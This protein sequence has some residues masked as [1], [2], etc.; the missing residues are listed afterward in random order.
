MRIN[1]ARP[2]TRKGIP[3]YPMRCS[4]AGIGASPRCLLIASASRTTG[5]CTRRSTRRESSGALARPWS[6]DE[7]FTSGKEVKGTADV[8][9]FLLVAVGVALLIALVI[10]GMIQRF[11]PELP[12]RAVLAGGYR[13]SLVRPT[14]GTTLASSPQARPAL[15]LTAGIPPPTL[16]PSE[17]GTSPPSESME[18]LTLHRGARLCPITRHPFLIPTG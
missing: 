3:A 5:V 11:V 9:I 7:I 15:L 6:I 12:P 2:R 18:S 14:M 13:H 17:G 10:L 1:S 4:A 8:A 16:R